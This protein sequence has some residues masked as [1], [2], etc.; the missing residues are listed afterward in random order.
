MMRVITNEVATYNLPDGRVFE[1]E[2][3]LTVKMLYGRIKDQNGRRLA[4]VRQ[5]LWPWTKM[6]SPEEMYAKALSKLQ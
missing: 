4:I 5:A 3:D 2:L 1:Y 6:L